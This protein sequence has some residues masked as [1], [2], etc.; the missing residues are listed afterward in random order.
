[1]S[2]RGRGSNLSKT[3]Y[4]NKK[5]LF[6]LGEGRREHVPKLVSGYSEA[7]KTQGIDRGAIENI[8]NLFIASDLKGRKEINV[9][10]LKM[11][12]NSV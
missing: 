4:S 10:L 1:M 3:W 11:K 6:G 8:S 2:G 12:S 7:E 9:Y 5:S